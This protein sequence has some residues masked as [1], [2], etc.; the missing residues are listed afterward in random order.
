MRFA[1]LCFASF[2]FALRCVALLW[3]A[4]LCAAFLCFCFALRCFALLRIA[5]FCFVVRRNMR[6]ESEKMKP[7]MCQKWRPRG[8]KIIAKWPPEASWAAPGAPWGPKRVG[9]KSALLHFGPFLHP[10]YGK[11]R[12]FKAIKMIKLGVRNDKLSETFI[13]PSKSVIYSA[14]LTKKSQK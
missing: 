10:N 2:R 14:R 4:S 1:L 8:P 9:F 11:I 6:Q 5:L 12:L 13:L 3:L 7:G